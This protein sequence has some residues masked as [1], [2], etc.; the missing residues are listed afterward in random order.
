MALEAI[1]R[2]VVEPVTRRRAVA[3]IGATVAAGSL[4]R[5]GSAQAQNCYPGG[6]KVC[7]SANGMKVCVPP[8]LACC[9]NDKCAIACPY[10]WRDCESPGNCADTPRLCSQPG[11]NPKFCSK[12]IPVTNG[13]VEG[14]VSMSIRGWCCPAD[15][16]CGEELDQCKCPESRK[17]P[18]VSGECCAE[19]EVCVYDD[20]G[21]PE[22]GIDTYC[23]KPCSHESDIRCDADH[24]CPDDTDCCGKGCCDDDGLCCQKEGR[25]TTYEWCCPRSYGCGLDT[26]GVCGCLAAQK[27]GTECCE[28]G[29]TCCTEVVGPFL[30]QRDPVPGGYCCGPQPTRLDQLNN[31]IGRALDVLFNALAPF[32]TASRALPARSA[33][34]PGSADALVAIG[35]VS[36]LA[37]LARES[38]R[39]SRPDSRY[40][41][42][43]R[44]LKPRLAPIAPSP[45]LDASAARALDTLLA[46]EAR[47][48]AL[49]NAAAVA[50]ARSLGALRAGNARA[51]RSQAHA[52]G[53][54]A[55]GTAKALRKLPR[56]RRAAAGALQA[57]GTP[58]VTLTMGQVRAAQAL[59]RTGGLPA[60]LRARLTQLGVG[61]ADQKRVARI[62][63]GAKP[64]G[65]PV[66]VA[67]LANASKFGTTARVF[68][69]AAAR[70]RNRPIVVSRPRPGRIRASQ[71][72]AARP[73]RIVQR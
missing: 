4:L 66:L 48:W 12:R 51:A 2:A 70:S 5:P 19:D 26:V 8:D 50:R 32:A 46:A 36:T 33:A 25:A 60:D 35:A 3:L 22:R 6:T 43:V 14:G 16:E 24:C 62:L 61:R 28:Q 44:V 47:A 49:A 58:E 40:R 54:F 71:P 65:G 52:F 11:A 15:V 13:C 17:C 73:P 18:G 64:R 34:A 29:T 31:E 38:F 63:I 42:P 37:A 68:A 21:E 56:L 72:A 27:C 53:H 55:G 7:E 9:S 1:A 59:V 20:Y 67:P 10:S 45:G 30:G 23:A 57:G 69:R 39:A 41:R